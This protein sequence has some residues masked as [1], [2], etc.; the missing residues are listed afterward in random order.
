M[1][2]SKLLD[3]ISI[4]LP[5]EVKDFNSYISNI[6]AGKSSLPFQLWQA[7]YNLYPDLD[8]RKIGKEKIYKKLFGNEVYNENRVAKIMTELFKILEEFIFIKQV[9]DEHLYKKLKLMEFYQKRQLGR[10][11]Q[12]TQ[13]EAGKLWEQE[14]ECGKKYYLKY[15][16][17]VQKLLLTQ[18][19]ENRQLDFQNAY[20]AVVNFSESE[21]L[22]LEN[23][24]E[25]GRSKHLRKNS[26][27]NM[28]YNVHRKLER[29]KTNASDQMIQDTY[30]YIKD[31][32]RY[33]AKEE[34]R[35][36]LN[37][38]LNHAIKWVNHGKVTHEFL[39]DVYHIFI[40]KG[41]LLQE[42]N[43][44]FIATYKNYITCALRIGRIAE[45][46]IFLDK[47]KPFLPS[48]LQEEAYLFNKASILFEQEKYLEIL[49]ML[50]SIKSDDIFYNINQRRL[51]IKT[52]YELFHRDEKYYDLYQSHCGAF[53]RFIYTDEKIPEYLQ[54]ANKSFLKIV[55]KIEAIDNKND[56]SKITKIMKEI[57][58]TTSLAE[59][60][61]LLKKLNHFAK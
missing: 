49:E 13:K 51:Y 46:N 14:K 4:L 6:Y 28:F 37:I 53:K 30:T 12:S 24:E 21:L 50:H 40:D 58:E 43:T 10:L 59:R 36:I 8:E 57:N 52:L 20:D 19:L 18:T 22:R 55:Q 60:D 11:F 3:L 56:T 39:L 41:V 1:K 7:L 2:N 48:T 26:P 44:L 32:I 27:N 16:M 31:Y 5:E 33:F 47:Y 25:T 17:E 15:E 23:L 9:E 38:F 61:W 45:A 42:N 35:E 54:E 34:S 29:L